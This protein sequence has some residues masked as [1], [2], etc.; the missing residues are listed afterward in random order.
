MKNSDMETR[1]KIKPITNI[2]PGNLLLLYTL[3][4]MIRKNGSAYAA[5]II[6]RTQ[7]FPV[8]WKVSNGTFYYVLNKLTKNGYIINN[9]EP[10][11]FTGG[12]HKYYSVTDIGKEYYMNN[13][14]KYKDM[15][16]ITADFYKSISEYLPEK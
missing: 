16:N 3:G 4:Y 9:Y 15:L 14:D 2:T 6:E 5:E 10:K 12:K 13:I 7:S 11:E 1:I 8:G